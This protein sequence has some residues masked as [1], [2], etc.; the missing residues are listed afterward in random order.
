MKR[1]SLFEVI[2]ALLLIAL[3]FVTYV[4][5]MTGGQT[6]TEK[7]TVPDVAA[8]PENM[9]YGNVFSC[10]NGMLYTVDGR[11]IHALDG[12]GS[13]IWSYDIPNK[14]LLQGDT[15]RWAGL[16]AATD[17][18]NNLY[19]IIS[20][21][22]VNGN[23]YHNWQ[24]LAISPNGKLLWNRTPPNFIQQGGPDIKVHGDRLYYFTGEEEYILDLNGNEVKWIKGVYSQPSVDENGILYLVPGRIECTSIKAYAPD[25]SLLWSHDFDEY[26][27]GNIIVPRYNEMPIYDNHTLYVWLEHGALALNQDG[28]LKW[29]LPFNSYNTGM[30]RAW[31]DS[32]GDVYLSFQVMSGPSYGTPDI[33]VVHPDGTQEA[34]GHIANI[35]RIIDARDIHGGVAYCVD[36]ISSQSTGEWYGYEPHEGL[37]E[38]LKRYYMNDSSTSPPGL[39]MPKLDKLPNN[40]GIND[41]DTYNITAYNVKTGEGLWSYTIPLSPQRTVLNPS[42]ANKVIFYTQGIDDDNSVTPVEWYASNGIPQGK[43]ALCSYS[44]IDLAPSKKLLYLDFWSYNYE[45]PAFYNQ[46]QCVYSGGIYALDNNGKLVWDKSMSSRVTYME[47][48][49]GTIIYGTGDGKVSAA[50]VDMAAGAALLAAFYLF[51]RF[52]AAG[53]VARARSRID[54]N[55]KRNSILKFIV[56]NPGSTLRDIARGTGVNLG[57]VRYHVFILGLN[58]RIVSFAAD[59]KHVRYFTNSGTYSKEEQLVISLMRRESMGRILTLLMEKPGL[60]NIEISSALGIQESAV[61]RYM[62]ELSG[63]GVVSRP[64][65]GLAYSIKNDYMNAIA[66]A[67][68]L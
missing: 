5:V 33:L 1:S 32:N 52:F 20:S 68:G 28:S 56:D 4:M 21:E 19:I 7:W 44:W 57:T 18:R 48:R 45:V 25:G 23:F 37:I 35:D 34:L 27:L 38:D 50:V 29:K 10:D 36:V 54:K 41:L 55:E 15:G 67:S 12:N 3:L 42:N 47:E 17:N 65:S 31:F 24:F 13:T 11:N 14:F 26:G 59:D 58:H 40:R 61:S 53:T 6:A 63:K 43:K 2:L 46:S 49:N 9:V 62:K 60:T 64:Q 8:N 66:R 22:A 16:K 51:L 39:G 30:H